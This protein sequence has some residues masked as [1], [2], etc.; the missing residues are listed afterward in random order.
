MMLA[1][2]SRSSTKDVDAVVRPR[3]PA[4]RLAKQVA[5]ELN[6]PQDWLNDQVRTFLAPAE[7]FREIPIDLPGLHL[8]APTAGYLLAMKSLACRNMLPGYEGDIGDLKF[9]IRKMHIRSVE[10]I[11]KHIDR[12]Y[13]DDVMLPPHRETLRLLIEEI[14]S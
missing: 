2:D 7:Q 10:E 14:E 5:R 12:Y 11:Q 3:E 6:L 4:L 13:A 1:Y 8:T 9:L